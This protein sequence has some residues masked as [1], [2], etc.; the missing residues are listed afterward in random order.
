M[1]HTIITDTMPALLVSVF[2]RRA[3]AAVYV[4]PALAVS[5]PR[6]LSA[7]T[8]IH[9]DGILREEWLTQERS[10][11]M[12]EEFPIHPTPLETK[13]HTLAG[14]HELQQMTLEDGGLVYWDDG[15]DI[16]D[17]CPEILRSRVMEVLSLEHRR[18]A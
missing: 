15:R 4:S 8:V 13:L 2:H 6:S 18:A 16:L 5:V 1:P 12:P 10:Q 9:M 7:G 14:R 17:V 3:L 11:A